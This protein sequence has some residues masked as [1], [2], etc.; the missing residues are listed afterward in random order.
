[1]RA[2]RA[3]NLWALGRGQA[4]PARAQQTQERSTETADQ[5]TEVLVP[6]LPPLTVGC[7]PQ[8]AFLSGVRFRSLDPR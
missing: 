1:M 4:V 5:A 7:V 2:Q 8:R 6:P 3:S